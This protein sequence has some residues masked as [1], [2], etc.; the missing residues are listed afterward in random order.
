MD[1][2]WLAC[3][4]DG[5]LIFSSYSSCGVFSL[6]QCELCDVSC[7]GSTVKGLEGLI[8]R[9]RRQRR[10]LVFWTLVYWPDLRSGRFLKTLGISQHHTVSRTSLA[11]TQDV[12][13][14]ALR[15]G[16]VCCGRHSSIAARCI[17]MLFWTSFEVYA[18][19]QLPTGTVLLLGELSIS[20][21]GDGHL[22][23]DAYIIAWIKQ[24]GRHC[25]PSM[26]W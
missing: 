10:T 14:T 5:G 6:S 22:M 2:S 9:G 17:F 8:I 25:I 18:A 15:C 3:E 19:S 20:S 24:A 11:G 4:L 16:T 13:A 12:L 23:C 26:A 21:N 1:P 7:A